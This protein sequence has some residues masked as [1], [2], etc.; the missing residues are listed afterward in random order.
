MKSEEFLAWLKS[1]EGK[2][3]WKWDGHKNLAVLTSG[4]VSD[5]YANCTELLELPRLMYKVVHGFLQTIDWA[6]P[7]LN[8]AGQGQRLIDVTHVVGPAFGAVQLTHEIAKALDCRAMFLEPITRGV[9]KTILMS[10]FNLPQ[11][12]HVLLVDDVLSTGSTMRAIANV[13]RASNPR[14]TYHPEILCLVD[15]LQGEFKLDKNR[16]IYVKTR[17]FIQIEGETWDSMADV[18]DHLKNCGQMRPKP[19]WFALNDQKL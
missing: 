18:P 16:G 9:N 6:D 14:I 19:C 12:A 4:K 5:V 3:Y 13:L 7:Q 1:D 2:G 11:D 8:L 15:R 17:G 10:R